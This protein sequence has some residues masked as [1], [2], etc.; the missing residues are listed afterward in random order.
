MVLSLGF[1]STLIDNQALTIAGIAEMVGA[2]SWKE[3]PH[4]LVFQLSEEIKMG[5]NAFQEELSKA[6]QNKHT[7]QAKANGAGCQK[8]K[9]KIRNYDLANHTPMQGMA[10]IRELKDDIMKQGQ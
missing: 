3:E 5:Y 8:L 6:N 2:N 4:G 9:D 10:F 7:L 1:P